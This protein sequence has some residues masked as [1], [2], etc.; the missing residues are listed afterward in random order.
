[1]FLTKVDSTTVKDELREVKVLRMGDKDVQTANEIAPF[2]IDSNPLKDMV[3]VYGETSNNGDTVIVGYINKNR[4]AAVGETRIYSTDES[5][6]EKIYIHLK[7]DGTMEIGGATDWMVR[8]S[9]L[10][11]AFNDLKGTVNDLV[12]T[13]NNHTHTYIPGTLSPIPSAATLTTAT[14]S[15]ADISPAKIDEI[16]TL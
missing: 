12:D 4:L 16:K 10:E 1:M 6:A 13:F 14:P 2:G 3:A 11:T 15:S 8:Y 9:A 5:G 7:N